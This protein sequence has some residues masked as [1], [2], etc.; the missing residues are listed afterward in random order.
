M[1]KEKVM[2]DNRRMGRLPAVMT[3]ALWVL[4]ASG[5]ARAQAFSSGSNGSD[6]ALDLTG[7]P[8]GTTVEFDPVALGKDP[9]KDNIFHFTTITIPAGVTLKLTTAKMPR[10]SVYWL[11][12]G[13]V[14]IKGT[15]DLSGGAG[16]PRSKTTADRKPSIPGPGGFPGG[17]GGNVG[18]QSRGAAHA[19]AGPAAGQGLANNTS[20]QNGRGAGPFGNKFLVP[21]VGGSGGAGGVTGEFEWWAGGGGAGGGAL[22]IASTVSIS[23]TGAILANGGYGGFGTG[24]CYQQ[25]SGG[26]GSGGAIRLVAPVLQGS[27]TLRVEQGYVNVGNGCV[28]S[29]E[30]YGAPGIVRLEAF[31]HSWGYSIPSGSY[32]SG[33]PISSFVPSTPPPSIM[34]TSIGGVAVPPSPTGTFEMPDAVI[35]T[36]APV[37]VQIQAKNVPPGSVPKLYLFSLEGADQIL[38][39]T[40]LVGSLPT[41]TAGASVTFPSG[42]TRGYVRV[43]W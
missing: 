40:P 17:I 6:G 23:V 13:A 21:L 24:G 16:H 31:Q 9:E 38:D 14:D 29:G 10:A 20:F 37:E 30:S 39:A 22:L 33:S 1:K 25:Y 42:F 41:S 26:G 28:Q 15:V 2:S 11:A 7:T 35:N 8:S 36:G 4:C 19:G 5:V 27:G 18:P 3:A 43:K 32:S 12:T 34:V